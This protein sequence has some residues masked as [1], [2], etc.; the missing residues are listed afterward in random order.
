MTTINIRRRHNEDSEYRAECLRKVAY[1]DGLRTKYAEWVD[2][3]GRDQLL[4]IAS[5]IR[6]R[7]LESL[8]DAVL[9]SGTEDIDAEMKH[10]SRQAET[11]QDPLSYV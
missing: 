1:Y 3:L 11:R 2:T 8:K 10:W 9:R 7:D 4:R 5:A 6:V